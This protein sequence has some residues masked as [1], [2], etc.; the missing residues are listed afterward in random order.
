MAHL[1]IQIMTKY[2][3]LVLNTAFDSFAISPWLHSWCSSRNKLLRYTYLIS[4]CR[5]GRRAWVCLDDPL[6]IDLPMALSSTHPPLVHSPPAFQ[7]PLPLLVLCH[8]WTSG[9]ADGASPTDM[10]EIQAGKHG[11]MMGKYITARDR[12]IW[13]VWEILKDTMSLIPHRQHWAP[14]KT[15]WLQ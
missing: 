12:I 5:F 4:V 15:F 7:I 8:P 14:E 2:D 11:E 1:A 9:P 3:D 6:G 10:T 13:F